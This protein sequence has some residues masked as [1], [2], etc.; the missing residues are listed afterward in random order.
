MPYLLTFCCLLHFIA[1]NG[2]IRLALSN[3]E[4]VTTFNITSLYL[5]FQLS[6]RAHGNLFLLFLIFS[7]LPWS[8]VCWKHGR[9]FRRSFRF[10]CCSVIRSRWTSKMSYLQ[11]NI[12]CNHATIHML[13][14]FLCSMHSQKPFDGANLSKMQETSIWEQSDTQLWFRQCGETMARISVQ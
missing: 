2:I 4:R 6:G 14:F 3:H 8:N 1:P 12:R 11:G 13:P 9:R 10:Q 7:K 5:G